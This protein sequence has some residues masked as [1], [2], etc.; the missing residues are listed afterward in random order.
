MVKT[1]RFYA[2][3]QASTERHIPVVMMQAVEEI[4]VFREEDTTGVRK[5]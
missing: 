4:P 2:D 3:Y 5:F 1:Y